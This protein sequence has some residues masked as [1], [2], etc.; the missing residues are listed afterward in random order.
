M[1]YQKGHK[2]IAGS[3]RAKGTPNKATSLKHLLEDSLIKNKSKAIK[4]LDKMYNN[5]SDFKWLMSLKASLE[6]RE[7]QHSGSIDI[8][9]A[10]KIEK[11]RKRAEKCCKQ[12]N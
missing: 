1:I 4:L 12:K 7:L 2:R 11:A 6:P 9:L 10:G 3:G 8:G 5:K